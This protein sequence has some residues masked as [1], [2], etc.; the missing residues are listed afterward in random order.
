MVLHMSILVQTMTQ[1][2]IQYRTGLVYAIQR[3]DLDSAIVFIYG[4]WAMLPKKD[5]EWQDKEGK[6]HV[7]LP[8]V[9]TARSL[10]DMAGS[11]L[12]TQKWKWVSAGVV[13]IEERISGWVHHNIDRAQMS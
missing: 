5:R 12:Q 9:P 2:W 3:K 8:A 10:N 4:M 11:K 6:V 1:A 13:L 7:K